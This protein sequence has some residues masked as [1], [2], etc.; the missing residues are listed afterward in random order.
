MSIYNLIK[1][2]FP[3]IVKKRM[4]EE[5]GVPSLSWSLKN[6]KKI[7]LEPKVVYDIGAYKGEWALEFASIF[8]KADIYMFEAQTSKEFHLKRLAEE[9]IHFKYCISLLGSKDGEQVKFNE[10]ETGSHVL[11]NTNNNI[12][13]KNRITATLDNVLKSN[14]WPLPDFLKLDVQGF[15][16]EVLKGASQCLVSAEFC[17][18]EVTLLD[19]GGKWPE[20]H[21]SINFMNQVGFKAYDI[22]QLIRRPYD[23]ALWQ[24]DFLFVKGDSKY[25]SQ[26]R[27]R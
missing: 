3:G 8:P 2:V 19:L 13:A 1:G 12:H 18:L 4:K 21:E 10:N 15:E 5:L 22:S 7:G 27:W 20:L 23:N 14:N 25:V 24:A 26:K 16:L 17:M 11:S 9:N 6:L